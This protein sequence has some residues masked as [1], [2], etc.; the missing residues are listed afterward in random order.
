MTAMDVWPYHGL[1]ERKLDIVITSQ[2]RIFRRGEPF[3]LNFLY[4]WCICP[5]AD[6]T[7]SRFLD[8][9]N[10]WVWLEPGSRMPGGMPGDGSR[11]PDWLW[12]RAHRLPP[13]KLGN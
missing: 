6:K 13:S 12:P 7:A 5:G 2:T 1:G 9:I 4:N 11:D 10:N 3:V 8:T